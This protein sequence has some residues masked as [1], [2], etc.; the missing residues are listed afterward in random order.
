MPLNTRKPAK[1][2]SDRAEI[3][4]RY[5]LGEGQASIGSSLG[6]SQQQVSYDLGV[7]QKR[8]RESALIDIDEAKGK[9]L[10]RIDNLERTYWDA[11]Q[12]SLSERT[13]TRTKRREQLDARA[14]G[15]AALHAGHSE[16]QLQREQRDGNPAFL[17]GVQ[18]CISKRVELLGLAEPTRVDISLRVRKIAQELGLD[19]DDAVREAERIVRRI[20]G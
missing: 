9:E 18:W 7:L 10:A 8:W 6:I 1:R 17:Q 19:P 16:A 13:V 14:D 2:E 5:L 4:R 12:R 15:D 20:D 3:A 11:W